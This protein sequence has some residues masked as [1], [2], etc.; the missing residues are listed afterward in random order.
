MHTQGANKGHVTTTESLKR[1][2][3]QRGRVFTET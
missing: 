1:L 3:A 2:Q